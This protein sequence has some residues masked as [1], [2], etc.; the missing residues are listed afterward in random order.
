MMRKAGASHNLE[1]L[2]ANMLEGTWFTMHG[3]NE[4]AN[5]HLGTRPGCPL[6]DLSFC[7]LLSQLLKDLQAELDMYGMVS[8]FQWDGNRCASTSQK[9][10]EG[11]E[12][13]LEDFF[14]ISLADDLVVAFH[15]E[16]PTDSISKATKIVAVTVDLFSSYGLQ[17]SFDTGK[18]E[19]MLEIR[20]TGA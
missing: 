1:K 20:G 7:L 11:S 15:A 14:D 2:V 5:T 6:A 4:V 19:V 17:L 18:T 8:G 9:P 3:F 13:L 16:L 12:Y 10:S